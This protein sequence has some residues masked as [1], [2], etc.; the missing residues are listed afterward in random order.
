MD[1]QYYGANCVV[2]VNKDVRVVVDDNLE[3]L[4]AKPVTKQ[5]DVALFTGPHKDVSDLARLVIDQPGEYEVSGLSIVGIPAQGHMDLPNTQGTTMYK[6]MANDVTYLLSGH[7]YPSLSEAQLEAIGM[8]DV[9]FVP[10]GGNGYT[11]DSTGALELIK[12]VEPKLVV[13]THYAEA[14]LHYPVEQQPLDEVLKNL[15]LE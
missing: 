14:G 10:V 7:I 11:L 6:I 12:K 9:L 4:G 1:V 5:G 2:L 3:E 13:P 15:R 8:V